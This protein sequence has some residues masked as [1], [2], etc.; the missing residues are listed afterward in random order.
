MKQ[1]EKISFIIPF[2]D[3]EKDELLN[4][5]NSIVDE[6]F[7]N[8]EIIIVND[9]YNNDEIIETCQKICSNK[10]IKYLYQENSGSAVAR[11]YGIDSSEGEFIMFLDADDMLVSGFKTELFKLIENLKDIEFAIFDYSHWAKYSD[12]IQTLH[13]KKNFIGEKNYVLSNI[14]FNPSNGFA[15]GSVWAKI[16]SRK[17]LDRYHI[18]FK[19]ELRKAQD[20]RFML[21]VVYRAKNIL[22]YPIHSYK[23]KMNSS[24]TCNRMNYNMIDYY[25]RLYNSIIEFKNETQIED[26]VFKFV[27]YCI[28]NEVVTTTVFHLE[29]KKSYFLK[30]KEFLNLYNKYLLDTKTKMIDYSEISTTKSKIKLFLYRHRCI[31]LLY[32]FYTMNRMRM[33][34]NFF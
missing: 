28:V 34:K 12:N 15:F 26:S 29:N 27:E 30:R 25:E 31:F 33:K 2:Y 20:R 11:N 23:Y 24:S 9:G 16:F 21:D 3:V 32:L 14:L 10:N 19:P 5:V 17:F 22:Y 6:K 4:C 7:S 18:R 8:Y 1:M 13:Y